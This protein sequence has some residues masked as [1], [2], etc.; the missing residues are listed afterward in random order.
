MLVGNQLSLL[1]LLVVGLG[2]GSV[3]LGLGS[4]GLGL[5]SIDLILLLNLVN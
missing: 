1:L 2:L 3:G 4:V 5:G